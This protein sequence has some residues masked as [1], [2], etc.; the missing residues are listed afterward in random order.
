MFERIQEH[1]LLQELNTFS[2][3]IFRPQRLPATQVGDYY[4]PEMFMENDLEVDN[5]TPKPQNP[6]TP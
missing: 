5:K 2:E 4:M 6:K 3:F 1:N